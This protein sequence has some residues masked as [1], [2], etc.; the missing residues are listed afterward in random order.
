[1]PGKILDLG[2]QI[3]HLFGNALKV[4]LVGRIVRSQRTPAAHLLT[5]GVLLTL[6]EPQRPGHVPH[7]TAATVGDHVGHLRGV[8][9]PIALVDVLDDL[10]AK[11]GFDI[12]VDIGWAVAGRGQEPFEQKLIGHRIDGR[13][14]QRVTDRRVGR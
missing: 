13:H 11:I 2:R 7:R 9:A 5:P 10:L 12:D 6:G 4:R 1:M 8:L 3:H 14:P